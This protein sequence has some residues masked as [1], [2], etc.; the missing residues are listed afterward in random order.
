MCQELLFNRYRVWVWKDD[1]ALEMSG[2]DICTTM[3]RYALPLNCK[4]KWLKE[5]TF[6]YVS[7]PQLKI[8]EKWK[9]RFKNPTKVY[10]TKLLEGCPPRPW[11]GTWEWT[12]KLKLYYLHGKYFKYK[13]KVLVVQSCLTPCDLMDYSPPGSSIHGILQVRIL[14]WVAIPFSNFKCVT[15]KKKI[16]HKKYMYL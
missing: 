4:P 10:G 6:H 15:I 3:W 16:P 2:D 14:K 5:W 12:L 1:Q 11:K 9:M 13:S 8:L 7:L